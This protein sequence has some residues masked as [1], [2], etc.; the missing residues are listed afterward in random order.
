VR[1]SIEDGASASTSSATVTILV[2]KLPVITAVLPLAKADGSTIT[3][4]PSQ[5]EMDAISE[6]YLAA[7]RAQSGVV[8]ATLTY[9]NCEWIVSGAKIKL[10]GRRRVYD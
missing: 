6:A 4:C 7:I 10:G 8:S 5:A 1:C 3:Q 9:V 2:A